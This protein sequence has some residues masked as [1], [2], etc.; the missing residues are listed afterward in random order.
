MLPAGQ[1]CRA[2]GTRHVLGR[3]DFLVLVHITRAVDEDFRHLDPDEQVRFL[4]QVHGRVIVV[5]RGLTL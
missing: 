3:V 2:F 1:R 4:V 5:K